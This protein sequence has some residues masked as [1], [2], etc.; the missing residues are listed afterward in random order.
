MCQNNIFSEL[1]YANPLVP[2]NPKSLK[3]H[4]PKL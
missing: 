2:L 3:P 1:S 4:N